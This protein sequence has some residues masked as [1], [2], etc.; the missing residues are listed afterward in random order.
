M[1][2]IKSYPNLSKPLLRCLMSMPIIDHITLK[3]F[4]LH[5]GLEYS[6]FAVEYVYLHVYVVVDFI[7]AGPC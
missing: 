7:L 1:Q 6:L 5:P 4:H 3:C 2:R